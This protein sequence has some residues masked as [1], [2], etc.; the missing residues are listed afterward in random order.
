MACLCRPSAPACWPSASRAR[1]GRRRR[2]RSGE[3]RLRAGLS[4]FTD[5]AAA[6][7]PARPGGVWRDRSQA[8]HHR[9]QRL[10]RGPRR[11]R[12]RRVAGCADA[13]RNTVAATARGPRCSTPPGSA[14]SN[15]LYRN[16][17]NGTFEDVTDAAGLRRTGWASGVC[18]GDYDND[19]WT[20]LF[21]TYYGRN[22]L[23]RNRGD[24]RFED[25]TARAGL[26]TSGGPLGLGLH[27]RGLRSRRP[28]R[29]LRRQLPA[30][31]SRH[32][33]RAGT[34]AQL[35]LQ[36][37]RRQLRS[38]GTADRRQSALSQSRRRH[39]RGCLGRVRHREGHRALSDDRRRGRSERRWV[40]RHLRGV[41][42]HGR[43]PVPQQSGRH[44]HRRGRGKRR[45]LQ[46]KRQPPGGHGCGG[47]RLQP[48][49]PARRA[50][51]AL[52][53]RHPVSL[54]Q[55]RERVVRGCG[56]RGGARGREPLRGMGRGVAG[57]GQRRPAGSVLRHRERVPG[58]RADA[59]AVSASGPE[60]RL[61]EHGRGARS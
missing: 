59:A 58:D 27:L 20:D 30:L 12:Q 3:R 43:D 39:L 14:P 53:R 5:I 36:G 26:A 41:R 55:S 54:S 13:Q 31:R 28:A 25:A 8:V 34:R 45:G 21:L 15:R 40:A 23:Y 61:P 9:D 6:C 35:P 2:R 44:V 42:L 19:G 1:A 57:S 16:K 22:V 32:G 60:A 17:R 56:R 46:R 10:R 47:R 33:E 7:G 51:D 29:S 50:Q 48:R 49:R 4:A 18:A 52:R 11:L 37:D 24:G 38:Q